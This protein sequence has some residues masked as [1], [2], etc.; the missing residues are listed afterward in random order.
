VY[1]GVADNFKPVYSF[2]RINCYQGEPHF[3]IMDLSVLVNAIRS[4]NWILIPVIILCL[5]ICTAVG[6]GIPYVLNRLIKPPI[7]S[8]F[9]EDEQ[10]D[11]FRRWWSGYKY[12][13]AK[14]QRTGFIIAVSTGL[15]F[16]FVLISAAIINLLAKGPVF[17]PVFGFTIIQWIVGGI[18]TIGFF[19]LFALIVLFRLERAFADENYDMLMRFSIAIIQS[20]MMAFSVFSFCQ[21]TFQP[22]LEYLVLSLYFFLF[23]YTVN[24]FRP[25]GGSGVSISSSADPS[26]HLSKL[27]D[28]PSGENDAFLANSKYYHD[29]QAREPSVEI[30][31]LPFDMPWRLSKGNDLPTEEEE[32]KGE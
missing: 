19:T 26:F 24:F 25:R 8:T 4:G 30:P 17:P 3:M 6:I 31:K 9:G 12:G 23:F 27:A 2:K 28:L 10:K 16:F 18:F 11:F 5:G 22:N 15:L 1:S 32:E 14:L 29:K 7:P 21:F 13:S 20:F